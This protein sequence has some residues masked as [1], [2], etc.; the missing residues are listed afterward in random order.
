MTH[1][2]DSKNFNGQ[3]RLRNK[4]KGTLKNCGK[5]TTSTAVAGSQSHHT[6]EVILWQ[7]S[8]TVRGTGK[9]KQGG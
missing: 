8:S 2:K 4:G 3:W 9:L 7:L 6:L 1:L 5:F